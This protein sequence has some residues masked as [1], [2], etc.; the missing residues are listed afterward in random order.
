MDLTGNRLSGSI[1][2]DA[3][4]PSSWQDLLLTEL[5]DTA[6]MRRLYLATNSLSGAVPDGLWRYRLQACLSA[7]ACSW[8]FQHVHAQHMQLLR[9]PQLHLKELIEPTLLQAY[10]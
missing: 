7:F 8:L 3:S 6:A 4:V 1:P 10:C 2:A 5:T 9:L